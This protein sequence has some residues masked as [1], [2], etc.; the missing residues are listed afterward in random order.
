MSTKWRLFCV[1]LSVLICYMS[2]TI[3]Q[4]PHWK[5][6][7]DEP[8]KLI[9]SDFFTAFLH[10]AFFILLQFLQCSTINRV[11]QLMKWG[12]KTGGSVGMSV[13]SK[14]VA[15]GNCLVNLG[16]VGGG[17]FWSR[18]T[19]KWHAYL[20]KRWGR[21]VCFPCEIPHIPW[22]Q[23]CNC[24]AVWLRHSWS[25]DW[26]AGVEITY[27]NT[28]SGGLLGGVVSLVGGVG[29][30]ESLCASAPAP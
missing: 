25:W 13:F 19:H 6:E 7:S 14:G 12:V 1:C 11:R 20:L 3:I 2:K 4:F 22:R 28:Q 16:R 18:G 24:L 15:S 26:G 5:S 8:S 9:P 17:W 29:L 30:V 23:T 21:P 27:Q 10:I